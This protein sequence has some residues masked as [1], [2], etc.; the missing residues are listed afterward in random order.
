[1]GTNF[2]MITTNKKL[3]EKY[4]SSEYEL[5]DAPYFGYEIHIGKRSGGWKPL[6]EAHSNAY[7]SVKEMK[8]FI[9]RHK[10]DIRIF[11]EY[12]REFSL[13]ELEDELI[14]WGEKQAVKYMKY[15]PDGVPDKIFGFKTYL[16]EST[17]DDYDIKIPYDHMEYE[18]LDIYG[19]NKRYRQNSR[20][21]KDK[22]GYDFT[23]GSFS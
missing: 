18:K 10:K 1:M 7:S 2:Y 22:D 11:D 16:V 20:Y 5:I 15:V 21:F 6:F 12:D 19:D 23:T 17:E 3:V 4:F 8:E 13:E 9:R 14:T